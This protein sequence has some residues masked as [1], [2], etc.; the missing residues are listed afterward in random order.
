MVQK[1][2]KNCSSKNWDAFLHDVDVHLLPA[3]CRHVQGPVAELP[4]V[5]GG[6][7][8]SDRRK[9]G[10]QCFYPSHK[11]P[12]NPPPE[13]EKKEDNSG[14]RNYCFLLWKYNYYPI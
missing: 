5:E 4:L 12:D 8:R 9:I 3:E 10:S 2:C 7:G 14:E 6:G 11:Y 1:R 13:I